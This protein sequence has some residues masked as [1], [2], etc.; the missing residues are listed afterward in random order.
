MLA[1]SQR[2]SAITVKLLQIVSL[3]AFVY[4]GAGVVRSGAVFDGVL[5]EL[6]TGQTDIIEGNVDG[7]NRCRKR[8]GGAPRSCTGASHFL[9]SV[10]AARFPWA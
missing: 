4:V 10:P 8:D 3:Q 7:C 6:K 1:A 5:D 2:K 9:K